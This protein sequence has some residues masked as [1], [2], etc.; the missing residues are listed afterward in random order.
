MNQPLEHPTNQ[1]GIGAVIGEADETGD[2]THVAPS[3]AAKW[4]APVVWPT[5]RQL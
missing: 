4:T 3:D 2:A 5:T 1:G